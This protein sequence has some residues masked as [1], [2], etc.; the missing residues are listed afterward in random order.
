MQPSF[1]GSLAGALGIN[2]F[3]AQYRNNR[4]QAIRIALV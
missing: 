2:L 3:N 1:N 4:I